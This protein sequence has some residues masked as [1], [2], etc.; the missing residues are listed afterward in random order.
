[1]GS[2]SRAF[3]RGRND[4]LL[5]NQMPLSGQ[6]M[7]ITL[8]DA[9]PAEEPD[10]NKWYDKEHIIERVSIPGFLE[11]RRYVAVAGEPKYLN[12][13]TTETVDVLRSAAYL[14]KLQNPTRW[15]RHHTSRF[16]NFTRA[17]ARVTASRGPGRG[18]AVA[19]SRIRPSGADKRELRNAITSQLDA[20]LDR[21]ISAH[22]L[23]TDPELSRPTD[24]AAPDIGSSDW[25]VVVEGT[26][27][28]NVRRLA[29]QRLGP[30]A[31]L[32]GAQLISFGTYRL[33]WD[34]AKAEL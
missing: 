31:K 11:A 9:E 14:E 16:R 26:D 13:Y 3:A 20:V 1:M 33:L 5:E 30:N 34:L 18:G 28:Q 32:P 19:F 4:M 6:G 29:E 23:E 22:L 27:A 10:F 24:T 15:T 8:M 2:G 17:V 7:L 12:F 25:Y 21:M